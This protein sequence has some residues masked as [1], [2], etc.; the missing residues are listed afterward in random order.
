MHRLAGGLSVEKVSW[1]V[2]DI[3]SAAIHENRLRRF[4][5][6]IWW[7]VGNGWYFKNNV[8][9]VEPR[10]YRYKKYRLTFE[11]ITWYFYA[12]TVKPELSGAGRGVAG[13]CNSSSKLLNFITPFNGN[14]RKVRNLNF[15]AVTCAYKSE[16]KTVSPGRWF[17]D[18]YTLK[19]KLP[20]PRVGGSRCRVITSTLH[21]RVFI[22]ISIYIHFD[23]ESTYYDNLEY[24]SGTF[25]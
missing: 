18:E 15:S 14:Y 2:I 6:F 24:I 12:A 23:E 4:L 20:A 13:R 21:T 11:V 5:A 10:R 25:L 9:T 1:L 19:F 17:V 7:K 8:S 22:T 16:V 3:V